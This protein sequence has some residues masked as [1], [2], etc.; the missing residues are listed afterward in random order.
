[1]GFQEL[2]LL[3]LLFLPL[4]SAQSTYYVTPTPETPCPGQPCYTFPAVVDSLTSNTILVFLPGNYSLETNIA[5]A[6]LDSLTLSGDST[7]LPQVT[8]SI[9][10]SQDAGIVFTDISEL[11][12]A[13]IAFVSC[14]SPYTAS[15]QI[16]HISQA[17]ITN[18]IIQGGQN[19]ALSVIN[20]SVHLSKSEFNNNSARYSAGGALAI[21][22]SLIDISGNS[23]TNNIASST[24]GSGGGV[25]M[26]NS[27]ANISGNMFINNSASVFGGG[28]YLE[29]S[30]VHFASNTFK[31]NKIRL[32]CSSVTLCGGDA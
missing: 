1:M 6:G 21:E 20:S 9:L 32:C 14:G 3:L 13:D 11:F 30:T 16:E 17:S 2:A 27:T 15:V 29:D 24:H 4:C 8:T 12:I 28:V 25:Y 10:C 5:F 22:S 26:N 23:F 18:C 19:G 31:N 7:S